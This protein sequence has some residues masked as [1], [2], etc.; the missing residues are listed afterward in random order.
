M[1]WLAD[2][3]KMEI[4]IEPVNLRNIVQRYVT[5]LLFFSMGGRDWNH[6]LMFLS[7]TNECLWSSYNPTSDSY[8]G[9]NC[10]LKGDVTKIE[11]GEFY[12]S[13]HSVKF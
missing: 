8:G 1:K 11:L 10:N 6:Q 12:F 5:S 2:V 13:A 7:R 4:S 3:D 9:V